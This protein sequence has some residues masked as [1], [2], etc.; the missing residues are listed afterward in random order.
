MN[1]AVE[2]E[3]LGHSPAEIAADDGTVRVVRPVIVERR[4]AE[5]VLG[6]LG[7]DVEDEAAVETGELVEGPGLG[8]KGGAG[9]PGRRPGLLVTG[10]LHLADDLD[11][12]ALNGRRLISQRL[13]GDP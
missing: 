11:A 3:I 7:I 9:A 2:S 8:E 13:E 10:V 1:G 12:P 6:D 4:G 5:G